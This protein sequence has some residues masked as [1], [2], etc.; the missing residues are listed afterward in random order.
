MK[1]YD[2]I[3]KQIYEKTLER[4]NQLS[5]IDNIKTIVFPEGAIET[6]EYLNF[7]KSKKDLL[8]ESTAV[9][10]YE[11]IL[12]DKYLI[13]RVSI[14]PNT[15]YPLAEFINRTKVGIL[16]HDQTGL[17]DP[18]AVTV[19]V[20]GTSR[21]VF[22]IRK[23]NIDYLAVS[24]VKGIYYYRRYN[25]NIDVS[26]PNRH[27]NSF[28]LW[29]KRPDSD[30]AVV[31]WVDPIEDG[32][33][34][35]IPIRAQGKY[36]VLL[37]AHDINFY[38]ITPSSNEKFSYISFPEEIGYTDLD[39]IFIWKNFQ[40]GFIHPTEFT[41]LYDGF[42]V[43]SGS[44]RNYLK[45]DGSTGHVRFG[46]FPD[47]DEISV[48][49]IVKINKI[50][51]N[52]R[53]I[54]KGN[55]NNGWTM[56]LT[57][58]NEIAF[59][60]K[61][62]SDTVCV[63]SKGLK[64]GIW[65][66]I[67]AT[68]KSG[69]SQNLYINTIPQ[70]GIYTNQPNLSSTSSLYL[71]RRIV[72]SSSGYGDIEVALVEIYNK[73][74]NRS[75]I[76]DLHKNIPVTDGLIHRW[77]FDEGDGTT[78]Y[79]SVGTTNGTIYGTTFW[80]QG[81]VD[82]VPRLVMFAKRQNFGDK[83]TDLRHKYNEYK[84][85]M[86]EYLSDTLPEFI[87][88]FEP[89]EPN[90]NDDTNI[91]DFQNKM[92]EASKDFPNFVK[93]YLEKQ[94]TI[95]FKE[96]EIN[97]INPLF[98]RSSKA[99]SVDG[100]YTEI[101][102]NIP[103]YIDSDDITKKGIIIEESVTN[104][105]PDP[106]FENSVLMTETDQ[107]NPDNWSISE[108]DKLIE[109]SVSVDKNI[110]RYTAVNNDGS[111]KLNTPSF[112]I[113]KSSPISVQFK[114][115]YIHNIGVH[116]LW[117]YGNAVGANAISLE[118][119]LYE[120][121]L[122]DD[123]F[124]YKEY[125]IPG[126]TFI[127]SGNT[128]AFT[129]FGGSNYLDRKDFYIKEFQVT[130][131]A[132]GGLSFT[133][134]AKDRELIKVPSKQVLNPT[135]GTFEI[136]FTPKV[137]VS[138]ARII[139]TNVSAE[140]SRF[141]IYIRPNGS[142]LFAIAGMDS[143]DK[144]ILSANNVIAPGQP[145][146]VAMAW[147]NKTVYAYINGTLIGSK[148]I[149]SDAIIGDFFYI[150]ANNDGYQINNCI[151][152]DA[153][154]S[155]KRRT[156]TEIANNN[157]K[158]FKVD[159]NTTFKLNFDTYFNQFKLPNDLLHPVKLETNHDLRKCLLFHNGLNISPAKSIYN[160]TTKKWTSWF[161]ANDITGD[162]IVEVD[163]GESYEP[164]W[165]VKRIESDYVSL[166]PST[167][168]QDNEEFD[169]MEYIPPNTH[170]PG[171]LEKIEPYEYNFSI[172]ENNINITF[173]NDTLSL[174]NTHTLTG[175]GKSIAFIPNSKLI[176]IAANGSTPLRIV[177]VE[178]DNTIS[179]V[180]NYYL[181]GNGGAVAASPDGNYIAIGFN[182]APRFMLIKRTENSFIMTSTYNLPGLPTDISFSP[183]GK[184][185]AVAH[186]G[187]PYFTLLKRDGDSVSLASTYQLTGGG[188][189][190]K[191]FG[192]GN[193]LIAAS[194][195]SPKVALFK[196]EGDN[197]VLL[198]TYD[199]N[200]AANHISVCIDNEYVAVGHQSSPFLSL[201]KRVG[202]K[203]QL[204]STY[205]F[206]GQVIMPQFSPGGH[207]VAVAHSGSP[208]LTLLKKTGDT[209]TFANS[210]AVTT[211]GDA[212]AVAFSP[213]GNYLAVGH[214]GLPY[215]TLLKRN[216]RSMTYQL[217]NT[218]YGVDFSPDGKYIAVGNYRSPQFNLLKNEGNSVTLASTY[219]LPNTATEVSFSPDGNY[220]AISHEG[221]PF[222]TL[223]KRNGDTVSLASTY[224]L[225]SIG[226]G[227][228]FSPDGNYIAVGHVSSPRFTL[229]KRNGDSLSLAS[230]YSIAGTGRGVEYSPDGKYIVIAVEAAEVVVLKQEGDSVSFV[231]SHE[232]VGTANYA[233]FSPD[234]K[235]IAVSGSSY[236]RVIILKFENET[237][238]R[239][240]EYETNSNTYCAKFSPDGEYLAVAFANSPRFS[241]LRFH[242]ETLTLVDHYHLPS[243][244]FF[245]TFSPD[246]KYIAVAHAGAPYFTLLKFNAFKINNYAVVCEKRYNY[247]HGE[248]YSED[249]LIQK[250]PTWVSFVPK[251]NII[252]F[253]NGRLLEHDRYYLFD[254]Y[255][256]SVMKGDTAIATDLDTNT[257]DGETFNAYV[258]TELELVEYNVE[259]QDGQQ[260]VTLN[261][262]DFP[263]SKKYNLV[264]VDGRLI[265]PDEIKE[266]DNYRFSMNTNSIN[267]MCIFRKRIDFSEKQKFSGVE[268]KWTEYLKTLTQQQLVDLIGP[269]NTVHSGE[270]NTREVYL[271]ERHLFE[272]LY[273]YC[274]KGRE[275]FTDNDKV[276]I[277]L[278][279]PG[280]LLED[281]RVP[282][283]TMRSGPY[284]RYPL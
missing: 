279:L 58:E 53:I 77:T 222:F 244:G 228:A 45:L 78:I 168:I 9:H 114:I 1:N 197:L 95:N 15:I 103:R 191:F 31:D 245:T 41:P 277:P 251:E 260:I 247:I 257:I 90:V 174:V 18:N 223:L 121:R 17:I 159:E 240:T 119:Y 248:A 12:N 10:L 242:E 216:W 56:K 153:R 167:R 133:S 220:I 124:T 226:M 68:G 241:L 101:E 88:E 144:T 73:V 38:S 5:K 117:A 92:V 177:R 284:P 89:Y 233:S 129:L 178:D 120:T 59:Q 72:N 179:D 139:Q 266:I 276:M 275:S 155:N 43:D 136:L 35:K 235:Y 176:A 8:F 113:N 262:K 3:Y 36:S 125:R 30:T 118:S 181:G 280:V 96:Y 106:L 229:L 199:T 62:V 126:D 115:K 116:E 268:D 54:E 27:K 193:Y 94:A 175:T 50:R 13:D 236:P 194:Y 195:N 150:C 47:Y 160:I 173:N 185:I 60:F 4:K 273:H 22:I 148:N 219:T 252:V 67:V 151:I 186:A 253:L 200:G 188:R 154:V 152:H 44:P 91:N 48:R 190:F 146:Y 135:E 171:K 192:N 6:N 243:I 157:M 108:Y 254:P 26:I 64:E 142:I 250:L 74:L 51:N 232:I 184:Y 84:D 203:L 215:F 66:D 281:G 201:L 34:I 52:N 110:L 46:E 255:R 189:S 209:L 145:C 258:T 163:T 55:S 239:V 162:K 65:Y 70:T 85:Y 231:D 131:K 269:L 39:N 187:A 221:S 256:Y 99:T 98:I 182:A 214:D 207:Y 128:L 87:K 75:E 63:S 81:F 272:I 218:G 105:I 169:V 170:H 165:E 227:V 111:I 196:R 19:Y 97:N 172:N 83:Y 79:D 137:F 21:I 141:I 156:S 76:I 149:N 23:T 246:G 278:E 205:T 93:E 264:F 7:P 102:N 204:V 217:P 49:V 32:D 212:H 265:H 283:S 24:Y 161:R 14:N 234:G 33:Q 80:K 134:V 107:L 2:N 230:S 211:S 237:L 40:P 28:I 109:Y 263:F 130:D 57:V 183:D 210:Y 69:A 158:E 61:K 198:D 86:S 143:N 206:S 282:I 112:I 274:M 42:I 270:V 238:T 25:N 147:Q 180:M 20:T 202:N 166:G 71:G 132:Y 100:K 29:S 208:R 123:G 16:L 127:G 259:L 164:Y 122:E 224:T 140:N 11:D 213:D 82:P 249:G 267:N 261:N 37:I 104:L 225:P 138:N 271:A